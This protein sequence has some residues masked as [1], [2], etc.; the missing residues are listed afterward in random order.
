M[1]KLYSIIC[2]LCIVHCALLKAQTECATI[3]E[4]KALANE[5]PCVYTGTATTTYY[6]A[7]NG[8]VMQDETGAILLQSSY[9][10]EAN[11]TTIKVGMKITNVVGTFQQESMSYMTNIKVKKADIALIEIEEEE[12]SVVPQVVEFDNYISAIDQ[13]DGMAV[14]LENVNIRPV[15]GTS[16][17]EIYSLAS[18]NKLTVSFTNA[19]GSVVPA[20][21]DLEGFLSADY[22]GKIFRVGSAT[23]FEAYAYYTINNIKVGVTTASDKD[24]EL[25]D[26]FAVSNVIDFAD[27]KVV[28]IQ[29]EDSYRNYGL[30]VVL[31]ADTDVKIG[32]MLTGLCGKFE[33]YTNGDVQKSATLIQSISKVATVIDAK[34]QSRVLSNYVYTLTDNN[35]QNAYMYDATLISLSGG[36]VTDK[37][38]G[39]YFYVIENENGQGRKEIAIRVANVSD[40]SAYVGKSCPVQGVLDVAATYIENPITLILRSTSDF[41]ESNMQFESIEDLILA[42]EPA[43]TSVTYELVN[44]VLVTYKFSKGGDDNSVKSHY[45]IVQDD[46]EGIVL[47]LGSEDMENVAVGDSIVGLKGVYSNMRGLTTDILDINAEL[48][49]FVNVKNRLNAIVPI[50]VTFEQ[51]FADKSEYSN[52]VVVVRGVKNNK[53]LHDN[54]DGSEWTES[55]FTQGDVRMDYTVDADGKPYFTYYDNMDITGVVDDRVI[56]GYFSVWP[57]SQAHIVNLNAGVVVEDVIEQL[58]VYP[59][60]TS[61]MIYFESQLENIVIYDI[62]GCQV[63][64]QTFAEQSLDLSTLDVGMYVLIAQSKGKNFITK[65]MLTK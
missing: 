7:Y 19:L 11:S 13:Y 39:S 18:D 64:T 22:S 28:Y 35:M 38:N 12:V 58:A 16:L 10:S 24:I 36:V 49:S 25:L 50:E 23:S 62:A 44:P 15:A 46:S 8:V 4:V 30:R 40:L 63:Y 21:A 6:D 60:P 59:N 61:G 57:L 47:S 34:V 9:L 32:D 26:T 1:R 27:C 48:Q 2:A 54:S 37:G 5:A 65:V 17:S 53:V 43:G 33:P 45:A 20:R 41:L 31:P 52:R 29:E 42:G 3:A 14:K 51:L 55:Y 56:G